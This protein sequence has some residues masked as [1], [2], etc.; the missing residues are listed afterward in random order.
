MM[1][2][3]DL[4]KIGAD[5]APYIWARID[6]RAGA[7]SLASILFRRGRVL[8]VPGTS[9][10]DTGEGY[11]RLALTSPAEQFTEARKRLEGKLRFLKL[12]Q[13]VT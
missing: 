3:L 2:M 1:S 9:F 6:R 12:A 7:T 4:V 10:G 11:I 5:R 13:E 8:V